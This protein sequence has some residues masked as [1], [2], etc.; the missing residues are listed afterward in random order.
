MTKKLNEV[1]YFLYQ[2]H[3]SKRRI[4][5]MIF[6]SLVL[7]FWGFNTHLQT[8]S[9]ALL[10]EF[11]TFPLNI[12][13]NLLKSLALTGSI[14]NV[15]AIILFIIISFIPLSIFIIKIKKSKGSYQNKALGLTFYLLLSALAS[16]TLYLFINPSLI[17]NPL[18]NFNDIT[19]T[20]D[21]FNDP[22]NNFGFN[23]DTITPAMHEF[24][25]QYQYIIQIGLIFSISCFILIYLSYRFY[26]YVKNKYLNLF[27]ASNILLTILKIF[28]VSLYFICFYFIPFTFKNDIKPIDL[29]AFG[30]IHLLLLVSIKYIYLYGVLFITFIISR[31][32]HNLLLNFKNEILFDEDNVHLLQK[33]SILFIIYLI[34]SLIYQF[35]Y[36]GYQLINSGEIQNLSVNFDLPLTQIVFALVFYLLSLIM[37]QSYKIYKEHRLTI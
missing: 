21:I 25:T 13:S 24:I 26:Q 11:L 30:A 32:L 6:I 5:I 17:S 15:F 29:D 14:G 36:N 16:R 34:L 35:I 33:T 4:L 37:S 19:T 20:G 18:N 27:N 2:F 3:T 23:N 22:L 7:I 10:F 9:S 8:N 28:Y 1:F 31:N 12:L